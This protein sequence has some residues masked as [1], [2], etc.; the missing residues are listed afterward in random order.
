MFLAHDWQAVF[1]KY[2]FAVRPA[3]LSRL[4]HKW[5][6]LV[7]GAQAIIWI[8]SGFYMVVVDIDFIHGD[9][10]VRN[11]TTAPPHASAWVPLSG[12]RERY[13]AIESVRIKGLPGF[14]RPVYE[15]IMPESVVLLDA[16]TGAVI[17]PLGRGQVADLARRYFAGTADL[18]E[19]ELLS[20]QPPLEIQGRSLP[21]W[22]ARF[23]DWHQTTLYI[24]PHSGELVTRR[25]RAWRWFDAMWML[26]IMDY[27]TRTDA[28]N[29]ILRIATLA[30]AVFVASGAWL[31]WFSFRRRKQGA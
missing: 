10:L 29:T 28:N 25:H 31:L 27:E 9:T 13:R 15:L 21:L 30:G 7:V 16:T 11:L 23:D 24:H 3:R 4:L 8:L 2:N 12:I 1:F 5:L 26:H 18:V 17:S 19:L 6:A 22:R 20:R 14:T